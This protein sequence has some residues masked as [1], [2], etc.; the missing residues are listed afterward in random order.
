MIKVYG[1]SRKYIMLFMHNNRYLPSTGLL[2]YF[3]LPEK[4]I[5]K[6]LKYFR[7]ISRNIS[8]HVK[9][10]HEILHH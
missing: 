5:V 10:F 1:V 8:L 4:N 9:K 7:N 6:F 3:V 2:T